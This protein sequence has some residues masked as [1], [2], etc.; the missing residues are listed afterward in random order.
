MQEFV[1]HLNV[2]DSVDWTSSF[3]YGICSSPL[4]PIGGYS[5]TKEI[6]VIP[7]TTLPT[8]L[9]AHLKFITNRQ[10][11]IIISLPPH[12]CKILKSQQL[13]PTG[14][15]GFRVHSHTSELTIIYPPTSWSLSSVLGTKRIYSADYPFPPIIV[16]SDS[17]NISFPFLASG[18]KQTI[19]KQRSR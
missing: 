5:L 18:R 7:S 10:K 1:S 11:F 3:L 16:S 13:G 9:N 4:V 19:I 6:V 14:R 2:Y 15:S 17:D 8:K 12:H